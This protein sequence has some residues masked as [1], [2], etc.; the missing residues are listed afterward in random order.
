MLQ[1]YR[2]DAPHFRS[3]APG[4]EEDYR[5]AGATTHLSGINEHFLRSI[6][7]LLGLA[8]TILRSD[9]VPRTTADPSER[10][11]EICSA[12]EATDYVSG[13]AARAYLNLTAF[14]DAGIAVHFANYAGYPI[15][16]QECAPFEHGVSIVDT[17]MRCGLDARR[18]LQSLERRAAF[19]SPAE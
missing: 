6:A 14:R 13:P 17:L 2:Q 4:L 5:L 11:V 16:A 8:T 7:R 10:L 15:Y 18:H 12:R 3:I 19:L 9:V 1:A